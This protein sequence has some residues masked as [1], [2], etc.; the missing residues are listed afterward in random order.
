MLL[1]L[2]AGCSF[3]SH[4]LRARELMAGTGGTGSGASG[5][6]GSS[7][8]AGNGGAGGGIGP[9]LDAAMD[10]GTTPP[11]RDSGPRDAGDS[12]SPDARVPDAAI[13]SGALKCIPNLSRTC[14]TGAD[15]TRGIGVCHAGVHK[16]LADGSDF[17]PCTS[18]L[19]PSA[20]VCG[21]ELDDD[22]NGIVDDGFPNASGC[23][24]MPGEQQPCYD[25]PAD[26]EGVGTCAAGAITCNAQGTGWSNC[27]NEVVPGTPTCAVAD[28]DCNGI[29]DDQQ[30][31]DQDGFSLC[32]GD[33]CDSTTDGCDSPEL[34]NPGA[35]DLAGNS[36]DDDCSGGVDDASSSCDGALTNGTTAALDYAK[37]LDLCQRT[38][39]NA[40]GS[41]KR[42]GVINAGFS[43]ADSE[44]T[45]LPLDTQHNLRTAFGAIAPQQGA[46]MIAL[47]TGHAAATD[48][49]AAYFAFDPGEV[50]GSSCAMPADWLAANNGVVQQVPGCKTIDV[51][52]VFDSVQLALSIRVPTNVH[53]FSLRV[54]Y[55]SSDFPEY[56]CGSDV[57]YALAL[58]SSS[59]G[60]PSNPADGN[61]A[62]F[63]AS[64]GARYPLS[65][66]L[67]YGDTGLFRQCLNGAIGC[68][69]TATA[70]TTSA[71]TGTS[72]LAG[73]GF[74]QSSQNP[75]M[76]MSMENIGGGTGWTTISGNVQPGETITLRLLIWDTGDPK[77]D[78]LVLF[79]GFQWSTDPVD[80]GLSL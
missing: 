65:A 21:N 38:V 58:L 16:C 34:V 70:G 2:L 79:D 31:L 77:Y 39:A 37:A 78:S 14:Y 27:E 67:A 17:G 49:G 48:D 35:Y 73:T 12:G 71:C 25:G 24:C 4:P 54:F 3:D 43:L 1:G 45:T 6:S 20:D 53:G 30:D 19:L 42:W 56:V 60:S 61:I 47:S 29:N 57:D 80:P 63:T 15:G 18:E 5:T 28:H 13:D 64:G 11:P 36:V 22:C 40:T 72:E 41:A 9:E 23:Q 62:T 68:D 75:C 66:D 69:S 74:D 59:L 76:T 8:E 55:L 46:R 50:M 26:T 7:G 52:N 10:A 33:C 51:G 32:D 44:P